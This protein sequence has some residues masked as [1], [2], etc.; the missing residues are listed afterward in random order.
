MWP[1]ENRMQA[2]K[3]LSYRDMWR[4]GLC[5]WRGE[6]PEDPRLAP[7]AVDLAEGYRRR[8]RVKG[9]LRSWYPLIWIA[10]FGCLSISAATGGDP[11]VLI[12]YALVVPGA[13]ASF[14]L[15]PGRRPTNVAR[16]LE[17][18]RRMLPSDWSLDPAAQPADDDG[19]VPAGWYVEPDND[20]VERL[21]DGEE[22][23]PWA[24]P[25]PI[26]GDRVEA[27]PPSW[28]PHPSKPGREILWSG[29]GWT[30]HERD[31]VGGP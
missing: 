14:L 21:W 17:A 11:W 27:E 29:D 25:R 26:R 24:R 3:A 2:F 10:L 5:L 20:V 31:L 1:S 9:A 15:D 4:V 8:G 22:W 12:L 30:D 19:P 6:A 28:Q 18:S 16:S 23:T 13:V 7:A